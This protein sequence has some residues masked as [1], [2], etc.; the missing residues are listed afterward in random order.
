MKK[1][2]FSK[3]VFAGCLLALPSA[4]SAEYIQ[5]MGMS[6]RTVALGGATVSDSRDFDA[7]YTNPAGAGF[8]ARPF[9]GAGLRI[10]DT[11]PLQFKDSTGSNPPID[12]LTG[13][14][15]AYVPG[16][17]AYMPFNLG[18]ARTLVVGA[19]LGA[20]YG[21]MGVWDQVRGNHRFNALDQELLSIDI[22][23]T[24]ALKPS[25]KISFGASLDVQSFTFLKLQSLLNVPALGFT[26]RPGD[27]ITVQTKDRFPLPVPPWEF[28]TSFD[29]LALTLGTE[30]EMMPGVELGIGLDHKHQP[31]CRAVTRESLKPWLHCC[32][33]D[34]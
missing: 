31:Y 30:V 13:S 26:G 23:P 11:T 5:S 22:A 1:Q 10:V 33:S 18:A 12:T 16:A 2:L 4:A 28:D 14:E 15:F 24:I 9:V 29:T 25:D 6:D 8:F 27:T 17:G 34:H 7:F 32:L 20:P 3:L 19:G 21:I